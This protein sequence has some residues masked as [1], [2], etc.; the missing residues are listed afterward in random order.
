MSSG[1]AVCYRV[2]CASLIC[3]DTT[4]ADRTH[5][6]DWMQKCLEALVRKLMQVKHKCSEQRCLYHAECQGYFEDEH[7]TGHLQSKSVTGEELC[8]FQWGVGFMRAMTKCAAE[9]Q[10]R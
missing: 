5:T 4:A 8:I 1:S 10:S 9:H 3:T 2:L 7:L 6:N